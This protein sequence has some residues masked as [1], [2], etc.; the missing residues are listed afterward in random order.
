MVGKRMKSRSSETNR[1][2]CALAYRSGRTGDIRLES[3]MGPN[4]HWQLQYG[5]TQTGPILVTHFFTQRPPQPKLP[6]LFEDQSYMHPNPNPAA[7]SDQNSPSFSI[8]RERQS[9]TAD[10]R[11]SASVEATDLARS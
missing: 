9:A 7:K 10:R 3:T 6:Q 2:R 4:H 1:A 5:C 8:A 11:G